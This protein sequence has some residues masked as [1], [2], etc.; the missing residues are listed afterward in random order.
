MVGLGLLSAVFAQEELQLMAVPANVVN[1]TTESLKITC[2][3]PRLDENLDFIVLLHV[4]KSDGD[5]T[6]PVATQRGQETLLHVK[7]N[8]T[9][10]EGN[11]RGEAGAFLTI[12]ITGPKFDDTGVYQ[13]R[14]A[15]LNMMTFAVNVLKKDINV[16]FT[17]PD[18]P[19]PPPPAEPM[20]CSCDQV[21]AEVKSLREM[22]I[23][24]NRKLKSQLMSHDD[25]CR[26]SFSAKFGKKTGVNFRSNQVARFDAVVS[27]KGGAY[28]KSS[29]AF[30]APC[31]GQYF[32]QLAMRTHQQSDSGYVEGAIEVNGEERARTSVFTQY[33]QDNYEQATNG[34][35]L[36]LKE[37]DK[38][39][40]RVQT[41]SRGEYYGDTYTLFS[42]FFLSP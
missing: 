27:N 11:L 12:E 5:A 30:K 25:K 9:S 14:F 23:A 13:C 7:D 33:A 21:W 8:R 1:G 24:E 36:T 35:V 22:L 29:G 19:T 2:K 6:N 34:V 15:Y 10:A 40:V 28:D 32:F 4:E 31:A 18:E 20:P 3:P 37:G 39:H 42:G 16:T 38:V 41:N 26:V 17:E